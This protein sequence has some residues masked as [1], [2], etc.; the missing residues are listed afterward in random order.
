V[1][2]VVNHNGVAPVVRTCW[3]TRR[4]TPGPSL[5]VI[6]NSASGRGAHPVGISYRMSGDFSAAYVE[7]RRRER[8]AGTAQPSLIPKKGDQ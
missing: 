5:T 3:S 7:I 8:G 6:M 2:G 1:L 4:S